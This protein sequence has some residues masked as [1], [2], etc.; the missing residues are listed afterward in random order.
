MRPARR[1]PPGG[2]ALGVEVE[3]E[4]VGDLAE[5]VAEDHHDLRAGRRDPA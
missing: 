4:L 1:A 2:H 5:L 3:P